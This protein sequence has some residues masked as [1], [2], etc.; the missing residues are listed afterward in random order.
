MK[1]CGVGC[2]K[3]DK[4][5]TLQT[6]TRTS[7]SQGGYTDTWATLATVWGQLKPVKG[8]ER[9]QNQQNETPV[10]HDVLIR[11]R[12]GVTTANRFT[13]DARVFHIK[14]VINIDEA[15][16]YLKMKAIEII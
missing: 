13:Y 12:A 7:D 1:A 5:L 9:F 16:V 4:R 6:V 10:T 2:A 14:E 15:N 8:F 11:Y 3:L